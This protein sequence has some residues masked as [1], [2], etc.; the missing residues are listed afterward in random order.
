[1]DTWLRH[2]RPCFELGRGIVAKRGVTPPPIVEH[3]T[4]LEDILCRFV[5][6]GVAPMV[7]ELA[8]ECPEKT[9]DTGVVPAVA[10]AAHA[11]GAAVL[12]EQPLVAMCRVLA[13]AI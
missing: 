6:S 11:A 2:S 4:V 13:A 3:L 5:P 7:H 12:A 8:F 1:M 10:R 9:L